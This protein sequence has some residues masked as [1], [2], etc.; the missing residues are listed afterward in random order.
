[1]TENRRIV[2]NIVATYGRSLFAMACGIFGGRW[3]LMALGEVDYGLQ[4]LVGGL[5]A[6]IGFFNGILATAVGRFYALSVGK[7]RTDAT[8]G[9]EES[10]RWFSI[11]LVIHTVVPGILLIVGWPIGEWAIRHFLTIPPD[12]VNACLWV[13]RF[14][15]IG[16]FLGMVSVP[17]NAFYGAKQLIAELT[18]YGFATTTLNIAM[19]YYMVTHPAD[20]LVKY[21]L[22]LTL[23]GIVPGLIITMRAITR[24][25][26]CRFRFAYCRDWPRVR[27]LFIYAFWQMFG[28]LSVLM[29][30]QGIAILVNKY[31]GPAFNASLSVA[32]NASG[33]ANEL[34]ASLLGAFGPAITNAWGAGDCDRARKLALKV[35]KFGVLGCFVFVLPLMLELPYVMRLWLKTP[36]DWVV[37]LCC[38]VMI[39]L[40][41]NRTTKGHLVLI[42]ATGKIG[43]YESV[44]AGL[45]LLMLPIAWLFIELG[46]GPWGLCIS[47]V[48][49]TAAYA[50]VRP[51]FAARLAGLPVVRWFGGVL[52]PLLLLSAATLVLGFLPHLFLREGFAR[53]LVSTAVCEAVLVPLAWAFLFDAEERVF[54]KRKLFGERTVRRIRGAFLAHATDEALRAD[55]ETGGTVTALLLHLLKSGRIDG[56][57]VSRYN[58]ANRRCEAVYSENPDEIRACVG[59]VYCMTP[60]VKVALEHSDKRLAVVALGCQAQ[61]L[62]RLRQEGKIPQETLV[63]GLICG[64]TY[65]HEYIGAISEA[66]GIPRGEIIGFRFRNKRFGKWPGNT[67]IRDETGWHDFPSDARKRLKPEYRLPGCGRCSDKMN[68]AADLVIGDPWGLVDV[69]AEMR[70]K[71]TNVVIVRTMRGD[72][73]IS[74]A[75]RSGVLVCVPASARRIFEGQKVEWHLGMFGKAL[76]SCRKRG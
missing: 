31:F 53:L 61:L 21:A 41:T 33:K 42:Q 72:E 66:N 49:V 19:L 56:A 32:R 40:M 46:F 76:T 64:G 75:V 68:C 3:A 73:L 8:A 67:M 5:T 45:C 51:F 24:F 54:V 29:R 74:D 7:A 62:E 48:V 23:L 6:F 22:W 60:V 52:L 27:Q 12:R 63:I 15:C 55:G 70:T 36:P 38:A 11:A 43:V 37:P 34:G 18:V 25:P 4:G 39:Q 50:W 71:G 30:G 69:T 17:F 13:F 59:S 65:R 26:E 20:W 14:S 44:A 58:P 47:F 28:S 10:R 57:V 9:I 2:L 1:M 16:C 35:C